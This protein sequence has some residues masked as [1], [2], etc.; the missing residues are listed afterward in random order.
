M[1]CPDPEQVAEQ[2]IES[3][4]VGCKAFV[5]LLRALT[6]DCRTPT[7]RVVPKYVLI[8]LG[9]A[10]GRRADGR[11]VEFI[12]ACW[13]ESGDEIRTILAVALSRLAM[14]CP[15]EV[16]SSIRGLECGGMMLLARWV[17][18]ILGLWDTSH[19][20][21]LERRDLFLMSWAWYARYIPEDFELALERVLSRSDVVDKYLVLALKELRKVNPSKVVE[22]LR[23][24]PG[25]LRKVIP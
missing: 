2:L 23:D 15:S 6:A 9:D 5:E 4:R 22:R 21:S 25:L 8:S 20:D 16:S 10:M 7:R 12:K 1:P 24:R 18:P 19:L 11:D 3:M 13:C 17:Y 14:I